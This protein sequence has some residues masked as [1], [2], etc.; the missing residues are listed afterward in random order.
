MVNV[1]LQVLVN[2]R[3]VPT[4]DLSKVHFNSDLIMSDHFPLKHV[5]KIEH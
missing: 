1:G 5:L 2:R 4:V 3:W